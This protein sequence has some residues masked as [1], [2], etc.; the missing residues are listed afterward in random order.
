MSQGIVENA[1][2]G[3]FGHADPISREITTSAHNYYLDLIYNFGAISALPILVLLAYTILL[4]W[5][6]R[7]KLD[8]A[9][10]WTAA[11]VLF[12]VVIDNNLKVTLRQ[13][14]PGIFTFFLWGLLI[15]QLLKIRSTKV[16]AAAPSGV[17]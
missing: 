8:E 11:V 14:Y 17:S 7:K 9:V 16:E 1:H 12:L 13:P 3:M 10:G 4:L 6:C 15:Q 5:R 2:T